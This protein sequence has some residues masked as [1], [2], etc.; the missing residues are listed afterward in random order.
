MCNYKHDK[1]HPPI[2]CTLA[3]CKL[4]VAIWLELAQIFA[5]VHTCARLDDERGDNLRGAVCM[6]DARDQRSAIA[7]VRW[8]LPARAICE[9]ARRTIRSMCGRARAR[10]CEAVAWGR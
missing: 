2:I 3:R 10:N 1:K 7:R 9:T 6:Y 5:N 4:F 8:K